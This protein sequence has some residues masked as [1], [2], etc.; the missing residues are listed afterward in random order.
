MLPRLTFVLGGAASGKSNLAERLA[1]SCDKTRV[2]IATAQPLDGEMAAKIALHVEA[3]SGD[4]WRTLEAP[5]ELADTLGGIGAGHVTLVDCLTMWLSNLV[6]S[7]RDA[8]REI[9]AL[10]AAFDAATGPVVVVSNEV[11]QG[12]V[13]DNALS[14][15]FRNLQGRINR[16]MAAR[17]D[18]VVAVMA[19]LPLCL[20][21]AMPDLPG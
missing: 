4:G 13:P 7:E 1:K 17:S 5:V 21:G 8:E 10:L 2:Y 12:I 15:R 18:C 9:D 11:G 3:R 16:E 19:G 6:L 14:R 20:K